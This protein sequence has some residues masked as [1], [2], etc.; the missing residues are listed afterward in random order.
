MQQPSINISVKKSTN[1][2]ARIAQQR[3][4]VMVVTLFFMMIVFMLV[5]TMMSAATGAHRLAARGAQKVQ[6]KTLAEAAVHAHY[7]A[8]KKALAT[9]GNYPTTRPAMTLFSTVNG[10]TSADGTYSSRIIGS[11]I[12]LSLPLLNSNNVNVGIKLVWTF[13]IEGEGVSPDGQTH[14]KVRASFTA[15]QLRATALGATAPS[16]ASNSAVQSNGDVEMVTNG[17]LRFTSSSGG[18]ANVLANDGAVWQA[19][20]GKK[21]DIKIANVINVEGQLMVPRSPDPAYA[22]TV[23]V[24]GMGNA[25]G[26]VN[27]QTRAV[28]GQSPVPA[29]TINGIAGSQNF[30]DDSQV[31]AWKQDWMDKASTGVHYSGTVTPQSLPLNVLGERRITAPAYINGDLLVNSG[32]VYLQ[33]NTDTKKPNVVYVTGNISNA[34]KIYNRGSRAC[35]CRPLQR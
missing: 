22:T 35:L 32:T 4:A 2:R 23:G 19:A 21:E 11:P 29:N 26:S 8:I 27:Y 7:D 20:S 12:K 13:V 10:V 5:A 17:G 9:D 33:P 14:S 1:P 16:F 30:A 28:T 24:N 18:S 25:N 3:G 15:I 6:S 34:T 31:A